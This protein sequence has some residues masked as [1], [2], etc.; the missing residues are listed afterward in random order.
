MVK[1]RR[2]RRAGYVVKLRERE[3]FGEETFRKIYMEKWKC[4]LRGF[5]TVVLATWLINQP[6][7]TRAK[8]LKNTARG[9]AFHIMGSCNI[10]DVSC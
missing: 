9:V 8:K 3:N 4:I 7:R 10:S 5:S 6:T 1:C 2:L